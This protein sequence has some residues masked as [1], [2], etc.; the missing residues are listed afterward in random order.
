MSNRPHFKGH[1]STGIA[2]AKREV[3]FSVAEQNIIE[4][5]QEDFGITYLEAA[6]QIIKYKREQVLYH[7]MNGNEKMADKLLEELGEK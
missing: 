2:Q 1:L 6:D 4:M 5:L 7:Q 3:Y